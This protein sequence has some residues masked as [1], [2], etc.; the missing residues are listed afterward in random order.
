M[1]VRL[2]ARALRATRAGSGNINFAGRNLFVWSRYTGGD[3]EVN[4]GGA[5]T[6]INYTFPQAPAARYF[7]TRLNLSY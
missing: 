3:P 6:D 1:T 5:G 7:I 4:G 2:P